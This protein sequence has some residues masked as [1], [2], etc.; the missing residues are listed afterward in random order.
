MKVFIRVGVAV[1]ALAAVGILLLG[2]LPFSKEPQFEPAGSAKVRCGSVF[3]PASWG[4]N[5]DC[6]RENTGR[7]I[8]MFLLFVLAL[9][10]ALLAAV[11]GLVRRRQVA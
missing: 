5:D 9:P 10:F 3:F 11:L 8:A 6:E 1:C 7:G 4:Q 2:L